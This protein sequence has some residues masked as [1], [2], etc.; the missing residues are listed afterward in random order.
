G[1]SERARTWPTAWRAD[2]HK[3]KRGL[4]REGQSQR[5]TRANEHYRSLRRAGR[6]KSQEGWRDRHRPDQYA[7]ILVSRLHGQ[8][9]PRADVEPVGSRYHLRWIIGRE[10]G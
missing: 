4:R 7:R 3:G 10:R 1:E 6:T 5:G 8:S 2:H 9:A